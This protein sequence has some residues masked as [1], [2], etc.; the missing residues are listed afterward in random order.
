[1][2]QFFEVKVSASGLVATARV[3]IQADFVSITWHG[4]VDF[5]D[6]QR[7]EFLIRNSFVKILNGEAFLEDATHARPH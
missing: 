2:T 4:Y 7:A 1:M 3:G 6:Y 5:F